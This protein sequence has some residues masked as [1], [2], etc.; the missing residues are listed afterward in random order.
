[1]FI[2]FKFKKLAADTR[3]GR[4]VFLFC[5]CYLPAG[6]WMNVLISTITSKKRSAERLRDLSKALDEH[7]AKAHFHWA[8]LKSHFTFLP[9]H[10]PLLSK[11]WYDR[12]KNGQCGFPPDQNF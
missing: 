12:N 7:Q 6:W 2:K 3:V 9:H 1:M 5:N 4:E 11:E 10:Y 8:F